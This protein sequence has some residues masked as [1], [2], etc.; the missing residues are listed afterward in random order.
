MKF[1]SAL[2]S[3]LL[4]MPGLVFSAPVNKDV[5]GFQTREASEVAGSLALAVE[6]RATLPEAIPGEL[7]D[8]VIWIILAYDENGDPVAT[9]TSAPAMSKREELND[10]VIWIILAYDENGE[11]VATETTESKAKMMKRGTDNENII[12]IFLAY[13]DESAAANKMVKRGTDNENIILIFL[14]YADESAEVTTNAVK[15]SA[16]SIMDIVHKH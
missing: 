15:R 5:A 16:S 12:L 4:A 14:A 10:N 3:A 7:N 1:L 11:A 6:K 2:T 8:N 9:E 13:A